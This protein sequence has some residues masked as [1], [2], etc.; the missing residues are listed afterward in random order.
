MKTA[1][2]T[3]STDFGDIENPN[4]G[5]LAEASLLARAFFK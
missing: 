1:V 3:G 4:A 5:R 2:T